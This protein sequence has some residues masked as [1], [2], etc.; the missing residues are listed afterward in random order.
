MTLIEM[1]SLINKHRKVMGLAPIELNSR[2][3]SSGSG[4]TIE[5]L[6]DQVVLA[7]SVNGGAI[8]WFLKGML[9]AF[10]DAPAPTVSNFD[11]DLFTYRRTIDLS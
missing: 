6:G 5:V 3:S 1:I 7:K 9:T 8:N 10:R 4:T 2:P 11:K